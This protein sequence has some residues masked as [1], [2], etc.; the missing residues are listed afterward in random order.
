MNSNG[1]A[2]SLCEDDVIA[3]SD[4]TASAINIIGSFNSEW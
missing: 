3:V 2:F 4:Y 1:F